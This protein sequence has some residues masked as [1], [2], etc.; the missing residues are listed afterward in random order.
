M[1][2][3]L[4]MQCP[5]DSRFTCSLPEDGQSLLPPP[6][7]GGSSKVSE[8]AVVDASKWGRVSMRAEY[9]FSTMKG[10]KNPYVRKKQVTIR[11]GEDVDTGGSRSGRPATSGIRGRRGEPFGPV[12][13]GK[14]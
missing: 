7:S 12:P 11:L 3:W 4:G 1:V 9:D 13:C 14:R 8:P 2:L 10:R 5:E 6:R